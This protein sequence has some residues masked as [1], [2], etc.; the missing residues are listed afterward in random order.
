MAVVISDKDKLL[1]S[2]KT[3][4]FRIKAIPKAKKKK[5]VGVN[6][7]TIINK[8]PI[9]RNHTIINPPLMC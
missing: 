9:I 1:V 5:I 6:T 4:L 8:I 3:K 7:S 2:S